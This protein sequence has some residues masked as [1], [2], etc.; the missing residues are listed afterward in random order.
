MVSQTQRRMTS[1][2]LAP[3]LSL[4]MISIVVA[5][6]GASTGSTTN[7]GNTGNAAVAALAA[8]PSPT[9]ASNAQAALQVATPTPT[10]APATVVNSGAAA[11]QYQMVAVIKQV[12]PQVVQI[13]TD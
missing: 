3:F 4:V 2:L 9:G 12:K 10:T 8:N 13:S 6:C 11:L 7:L 1:R 5:A